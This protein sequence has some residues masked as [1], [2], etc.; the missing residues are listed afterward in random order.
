MASV[1]PIKE[2]VKN[3]ISYY[4]QVFMDLGVNVKLNTPFS[5]DILETYKPDE[6]ILATGSEP[7]LPEI[8]GLDKV[9][10]KLFSYVLEGA[11]PEGEKIA[12]IGGGM[13]GLEV[14]EF[15]SDKKKKV[16][17]IEML[18]K[19]GA[20]VQEMVKNVVIPLINENENITTYLKTKITEIKE[21]TLIGTQKKNPVNIE[22]DDLIIATGVKSNDKLEEEIKS[23]VPKLKKI[24][25]CKK[26][27]KIVD[28]VK[29]GYKIA[30][31]L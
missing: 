17:V 31:K 13:V 22:F 2:E 29:D 28:A 7:I 23:K 5:M 27:R 21:N 14:A 30:L 12:I 25:D 6:V 19:L 18:K 9:P 10:Y 4:N 26:P 8:A 20:N 1:A 11:I 24:G 3:M 16:V 15:L